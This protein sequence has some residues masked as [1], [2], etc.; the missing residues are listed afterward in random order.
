MQRAGSSTSLS[1]RTEAGTR[2]GASSSAASTATTTTTTTRLGG[3]GDGGGGNGSPATTVAAVHFKVRCEQLGHGEDIYLVPYVAPPVDS[4]A[5]VTMAGETGAL[6]SATE[7]LLQP[8]S[9]TSRHK[10]RLCI[11]LCSILCS[12]SCILLYY[13]IFLI[14]EEERTAHCRH[15]YTKYFVQESPPLIVVFLFCN[16]VLACFCFCFLMYIR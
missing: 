6:L 7:L 11:S 13:I 9:P 5:D 15:L 3:G 8:P 4:D 14:I 2:A 1:G 16:G 10:V 12:I